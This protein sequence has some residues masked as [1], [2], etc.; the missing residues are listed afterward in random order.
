MIVAFPGPK[1]IQLFSSSTQLSR[2]FQLLIK[3]KIHVGT[4][5]EVSCMQ[6][7]NNC[8]LFNIYEHDKFYAQ[9]SCLFD[10][11]LYIPSTIFQLCRDG[12]SSVEPV[13]S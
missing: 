13:L 4:N 10:L 6:L 3:N 11:I 8:W 7:L 1:V 12:V 9:L 2:K 5:E